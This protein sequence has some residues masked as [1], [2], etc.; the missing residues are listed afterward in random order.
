MSMTDPLADLLTR[1]RNGQ[2]AKL[3]FITS[4]ISKL[5]L[6]V[7]SVL[8]DEGFIEAFEEEENSDTGFKQVR[9]ALRYVDGLPVIRE[10][11]RVS[12]P[13]CRV[14]SSIGDLPRYH[15]GLGVTILSTSHGVLAD[16][17]ARELRVGGEV[18]CKVF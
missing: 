4:P 15:N 14:Y 3:A 1:V 6:N 11:K 10:L 7:L 17:K 5:R 2:R 8:K 16:H 12:K 18:L 9:I 13:G